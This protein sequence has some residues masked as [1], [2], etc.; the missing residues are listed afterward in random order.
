MLGASSPWWHNSGWLT[1]IGVV[2]TA[3]FTGAILGVNVIA[4][5]HDRALSGTGRSLKVTAARSDWRPESDEPYSRLPA[6]WD[7]ENTR[8][9]GLRLHSLAPYSTTV[10]MNYSEIRVDRLPADVETDLIHLMVSQHEPS[11]LVMFVHR[12]DGWKSPEPYLA[13]IRLHIYTNLE[14]INFRHKVWLKPIR[15]LGYSGK[16]VVQAPG[17]GG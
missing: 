12:S 2:A 5:L 1:V 14:S 13:K 16:S 17:G 4:H 8:Y 9:F 11:N 7:R 10:Y 15:P 3:V 6:N